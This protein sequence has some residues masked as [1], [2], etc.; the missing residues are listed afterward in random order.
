MSDFKAKMNPNRFR[1]GLRPDL[2]GELT[3]LPRASRGLLLRRGKK[4][5]VG[6]EGREDAGIP[7]GWFASHVNPKP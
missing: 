1:L 6:W 2:G 3:V 7:K 4:G 5:K